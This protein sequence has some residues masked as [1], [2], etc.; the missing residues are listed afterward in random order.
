MRI[1]VF[2]LKKGIFPLFLVLQ[3]FLSCA[4]DLIPESTVSQI[5]SGITVSKELV[6]PSSVSASN[7]DYRCVKLSWNIAQNAARY[8]I[9]STDSLNPS[10]AIFE[11]AGETRSDNFRNNSGKSR[12]HKI[13][14]C[15]KR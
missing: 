7:G 5:S 14:L 1:G 15:N 4:N 11:K 12:N 8:N 10:N 9:Y 3:V 6:P 13:L 2:M